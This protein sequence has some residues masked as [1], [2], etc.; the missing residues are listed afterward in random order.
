ME[1]IKPSTNIFIESIM[2]IAKNM[3]ILNLNDEAAKSISDSA[4]Y[5][6]KIMIQVSEYVFRLF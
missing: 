1:E 3:G 2:A 5:R 6:L 4:A